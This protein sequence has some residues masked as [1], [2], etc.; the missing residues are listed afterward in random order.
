MQSVL[1]V[2]AD[3]SS[4]GTA[5]LELSCLSPSL[6]NTFVLESIMYLLGPVALILIVFTGSAIFAYFQG[7]STIREIREHATMASISPATLILYL[8]Q[9]PFLFCTL[10]H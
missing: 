8:L 6:G 3:V 5:Y 2:Q 9:V 7:A 1:G 10:C 4:L